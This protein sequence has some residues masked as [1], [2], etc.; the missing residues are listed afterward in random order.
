MSYDST[1]DIWA[2]AVTTA[3]NVKDA[4]GP[5]L[6]IIRD[7]YFPTIV[8][9]VAELQALE[10][11]SSGG[12]SSS[13]VGLRHLVYPLDLYVQYRRNPFVVGSLVV[14][15]VVGLPFFLGYLTGKG[16]K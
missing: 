2:D 3:L 12:G 7:P 13:G 5:A 14:G 4:V 10:Q 16:L 11:S 8:Q 1:G 9:K 6:A 15:M